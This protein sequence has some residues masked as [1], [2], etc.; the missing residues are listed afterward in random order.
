MDNRVVKT[1]KPSVVVNGPTERLYLRPEPLARLHHG[2]KSSHKLDLHHEGNSD[3]MLWTPW[4]GAGISPADMS[5]QDYKRMICIE[6]SRIQ[7]PQKNGKL[8]VRLEKN[9]NLEG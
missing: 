4:K 5:A 6:T 3:V 1:E 2:S 8:S 9:S 7:K